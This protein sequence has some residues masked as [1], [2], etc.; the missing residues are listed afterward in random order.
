MANT[1]YRRNDSNRDAGL[2]QNRPLL[3]V[4]LD[5]DVDVVTLR[6]RQSCGIESDRRASTSASVS[7]S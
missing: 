5:E 2:L 7:P 4:Q 6:V 3:D 1:V